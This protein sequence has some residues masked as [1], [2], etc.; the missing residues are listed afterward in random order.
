MIGQQEG[1]ELKQGAVQVIE[2][3]RVW[4]GGGWG[5]QMDRLQH[6]CRTWVHVAAAQEELFVE[7]RVAFM[8]SGL[9]AE[10]NN[11]VEGEQQQTV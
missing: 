7:Q 9:D 10:R 2:W 3:D 6:T 11:P 4:R 5:E 1:N 8:A